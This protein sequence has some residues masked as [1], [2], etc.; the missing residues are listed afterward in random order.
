MKKALTYIIAFSLLFSMS[1]TAS[2]TGTPETVG[3]NGSK[4][5]D[6][7]ATYSTTSHTPNVYSVDI[8]WSSLNFTYTQ[9][10][11]KIWNAENHSYSTTTKGEWD[12]TTATITVT[13]HSN[14][15]VNTEVEYTAVAGTGIRGVVTNSSAVLDAGEVGNYDGADSNTTTLT[16][17]GTPKDNATSE[18]VKIG[19]VKVTIK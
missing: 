15:A 14:I 2:A 7:T 8:E 17:S 3:Q 1:V 10:N 6:V 16:I 11:T 18:T 12:K 9:K 13:N 4:E 19:T 5:I